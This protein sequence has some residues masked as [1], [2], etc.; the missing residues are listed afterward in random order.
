MRHA[1]RL[2]D[3]GIALHLGTRATSA[4]RGKPVKITL[5]KD[6]EPPD[7]LSLLQTRAG[8]RHASGDEDGALEDLEE[9]FKIS[10]AAAAPMLETMLETR[11]QSAIESGEQEAERTVT[12]RLIE[13]L[14]VQEKHEDSLAMLVAWVD[15]APDDVECLR[16]LREVQADAQ[17]WEGVIDTCRRLLEIDEEDYLA[18]AAESLLLAYQTL[19][20]IEQAR[21]SLE[22]ARAKEPDN[23]RV[24]TALRTVYE[25]VGAHRELALLFIDE[26]QAVDDDEQKAAYLRWAGQTLVS[27]GDPESAMPALEQVLEIQPGDAGATISIADIA[28][29]QGDFEQ[30]H[31]VL[32][33]AISR[34]K[35]RK[36][37]NELCMFWQRKSYVARAQGDIEQQIGH[38]LKAHQTANKNPDVAAELADLSESLERW[39]VA[40]KALRAI[41]NFTDIECRISPAQAMVRQGR[42][43]LHQGDEKLA[44]MWARR[45]KRAADEGDADVMTFLQEMGEA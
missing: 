1:K 8:M 14:K 40:T 9:A 20:Q 5:E 15:R 2:K 42:I 44:R 21:E 11:R 17:H 29:M 41:T 12:M 7:R 28:M 26:A 43:A 45:L 13:V 30:A 38:L 6:M 22:A 34:C 16:T 4:E 31:N 10:G 36:Y 3:L 33:E 32:D 35:G 39:D 24:R 23:A 18:E 37:Q 25:Q 27:Q 19:G